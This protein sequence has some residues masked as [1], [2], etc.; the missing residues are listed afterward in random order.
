MGSG[1][2]TVTTLQCDSHHYSV[3][4]IITVWFIITL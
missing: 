3:T 1:I 4:H 2:V